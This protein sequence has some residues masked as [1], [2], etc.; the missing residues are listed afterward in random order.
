LEVDPIYHDPHSGAVFPLVLRELRPEVSRMLRRTACAFAGLETTKPPPHFESLGR[1]WMVRAVA[2]ADRILAEAAAAFDFLLL[3]TPTNAEPAW[4]EF[5][6]GGFQRQPGFL[7]RPLPVDPD[8]VKRQ[9]FRA[10]LEKIEDPTLAR[11]LRNKQHELDAQITMLRWRG[12]RRFLL[13]GLT[14]YGEVEPALLQLA[15]SILEALPPRPAPTATESDAHGAVGAQAFAARAREEFDAYRQVDPNFQAE[16]EITDQIPAGLMVARR[17]L[18]IAHN[19][20]TTPERVE[21]LIHHEIGTHLLTAHNGRAQPL[22]LLEFG[23]AGYEPLQEGLAVLA[24]Y[25]VGGLNRARVRVLAA[26][27]VAGHAL[28]QGATFVETFR[29]LTDGHGFTPHAAFTLTM[30]IF[31]GGGLT[32]DVLYM[33]GL[34]RLLAYLQEH[35]EV[36]PLFVGKVA[37]EDAPLL[38]ELR[39]REIVHPPALEPRFLQSNDA[40][41]RLDAARRSTLLELVQEGST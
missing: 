11:L 18:L 25:L 20:H 15:K 32:K 1:R 31:R 40:R 39:R 21:P 36:E 23:S 5:S 24:E 34:V 8:L 4:R 7:Y 30:R 14:V 41:R 19:F 22:R 3:V 10:P 12:T 35:R 37:L 29:E 13:T 17:R 28:C 2:A 26:R 16:V 33:K 27:V 9:L 6:A 38:Q